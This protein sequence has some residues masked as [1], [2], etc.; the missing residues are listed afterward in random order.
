MSYQYSSILIVLLTSPSGGVQ[1]RAELVRRELTSGCPLGDS[2]AAAD[3]LLHEHA[4]LELETKVGCRYPHPQS[5]TPSLYTWRRLSVPT[6]KTSQNLRK[7]AKS[8]IR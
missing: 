5:L 4:K 2:A 3:L 6:S 7:I 1:K 8:V